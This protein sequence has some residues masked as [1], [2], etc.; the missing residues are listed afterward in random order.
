[1]NKGQEAGKSVVGF[2][3]GWLICCGQSWALVRL[4]PTLSERHQGEPG[5]RGEPLAEMLCWDHGACNLLPAAKSRWFIAPLTW[6][7][8]RGRQQDPEAEVRLVFKT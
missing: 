5:G 8:I 3:G 1:M 4:D 6:G 7:G 2:R